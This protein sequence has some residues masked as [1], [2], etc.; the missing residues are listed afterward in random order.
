[1]T[2]RRLDPIT[3]DIVTRGRM[4]V[5]GIEEVAQTITTRLR[6]ILGEYFRDVTQG[7]DWFGEILGKNGSITQ[8]EA[9]LKN[10][11][12]NTAGVVEIF[13]FQSSFDRKTRSYLVEAEVI[14][15]FS[16]NSIFIQVGTGDLHG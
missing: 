7:V 4:F 5:S 12:I 11:I 8:R 3:G 9:A 10:T 15:K 2:V 14:T 1:M 16:T 13:R 6:L